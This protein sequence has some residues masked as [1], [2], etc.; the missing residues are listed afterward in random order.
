M[1]K[2]KENTYCL[3]VSF[4]KTCSKSLNYSIFEITTKQPNNK[5]EQKTKNK[6]QKTDNKK[7]DQSTKWK[8][9][10]KIYKTKDHT[11]SFNLPTSC[12]CDICCSLRF[13]SNCLFN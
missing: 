2:K 11:F 3:T 1:K 9:N 13:F 5:T 4:S 8:T 12:S 6:K 10:A 7:Q